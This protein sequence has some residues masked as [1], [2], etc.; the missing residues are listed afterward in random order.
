MK[1]RLLVTLTAVLLC[2]SLANAVSRS[3][4]DATVSAMQFDSLAS[5]ESIA[6]IER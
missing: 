1:A 6:A 4:Q 3:L 2:L 5:P